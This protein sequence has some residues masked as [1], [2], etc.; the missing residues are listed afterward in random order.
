MRTC[1]S[2]PSSGNTNPSLL[3]DRLCHELT[4]VSIRSHGALHVGTEPGRA[5]KRGGTC[6]KWLF[7]QRG[8]LWQAL[9]FINEHQS[10]PQTNAGQYVVPRL[11]C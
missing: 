4:L 1:F 10:K 11:S 6:A 2:I 7:F 3:W 5:E 9:V 8:F